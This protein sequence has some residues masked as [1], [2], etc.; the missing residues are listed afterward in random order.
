MSSVKKIVISKLGRGYQIALF[1][2]V[3]LFVSL[4]LALTYDIRI[5]DAWV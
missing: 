3:G 5:T 4:M 1:C 2:A